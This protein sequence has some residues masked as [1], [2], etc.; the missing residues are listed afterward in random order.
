[1]L[2]KNEHYKPF[3]YFVMQHTPND[4]PRDV[5]L[6]LREQAVRKT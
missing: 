2:P 3:Y 5:H 1:M 4:M 6:H